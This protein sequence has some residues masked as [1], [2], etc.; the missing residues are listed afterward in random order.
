MNMAEKIDAITDILTDKDLCSEAM[1]TQI[2]EVVFDD[3]D[4]DDNQ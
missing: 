3:S 4:W 1:V 2:A